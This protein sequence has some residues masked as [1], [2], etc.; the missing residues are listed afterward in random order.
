MQAGIIG[1]P[2]DGGELGVI[3]SEDDVQERY[4]MEFHTTLS[5]QR[6]EDLSGD[7]QF[8]EGTALREEQIEVDRAEVE[9]VE[10]D[11]GP[12]HRI[13]IRESR[14]K[15]QTW[16]DFVAVEARD[17][18]PGFVAVSTSEAEFVFDVIARQFPGLRIERTEIDLGR[19][20]DAK[21]DYNLQGAGGVA[22]GVEAEKFMTWGDELEEDPDLGDLVQQNKD[23]KTTPIAPGTYVFDKW[24]VHCNVAQSG[25]VEVWTPDW[26]THE[27]VDWVEQEVMPFVA[28]TDD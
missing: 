25:W 7:T 6:V 27:F 10:D 15:E 3:E 23:G 11:D 28:H 14:R 5:V 9:D 2:T 1:V 21:D 16:A 4:G 19:F 18:H 26:T 22:A 13:R 8:V 17:G 12:P 24:S 20:V